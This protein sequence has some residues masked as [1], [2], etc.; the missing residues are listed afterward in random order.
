MKWFCCQLDQNQVQLCHFSV[1]LHI[2]NVFNFVCTIS[3]TTKLSS[4]L[5]ICTLRSADFPSPQVEMKSAVRLGLKMGQGNILYNSKQRR[6]L[7][8]Y[9]SSGW[10]SSARPCKKKLQ[11]FS[12]GAKRSKCIEKGE[13]GWVRA[14]RGRWS[15]LRR[16]D[17]GCKAC[18]SEWKSERSNNDRDKQ[19]KNI[20][21]LLCIS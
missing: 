2:Y 15:K 14:L 6:V 20:G 1:Q 8:A 4:I 11:S 16:I 18:F 7:R 17:L 5:C 13:Q 3:A 9:A 21:R 12:A 19:I 10:F